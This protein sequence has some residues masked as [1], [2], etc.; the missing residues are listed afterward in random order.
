MLRVFLHLVILCTIF[1]LVNAAHHH[2]SH[3]KSHSGF[4]KD[5]PHHSGG[6]FPFPSGSGTHAFPPSGVP[7]SARYPAGNVTVGGAATCTGTRVSLSTANIGNPLQP[8]FTSSLRGEK[9]PLTTAGVGEASLEGSDVGGAG[10][11]NSEGSLSGSEGSGFFGAGPTSTAITPTIDLDDVDGVGGPGEATAACQP[12]VTITVIQDTTVTVT[13]PV[14]PSYAAIASQPTAAS[15][16]QIQFSSLA[17]HDT[18]IDTAPAEPIVAD[19]GLP[20]QATSSKASAAKQTNGPSEFYVPT[21]T[22]TLITAPNVP[23]QELPQV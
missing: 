7:T 8:S 15:Q 19:T 3:R 17:S 4:C 22:G 5:F 2:H 21:K 18:S 12:P 23:A 6:L 13:S 9:S 20:R 11:T 10:L 14:I 1:S 16:S